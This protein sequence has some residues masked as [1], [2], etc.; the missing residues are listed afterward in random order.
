MRVTIIFF[1]A[2]FCQNSVAQ[3]IKTDKPDFEATILKQGV[4]FLGEQKTSLKKFR[5]VFK[6]HSKSTDEMYIRLYLEDGVE[7]NYIE[8]FRKTFQKL[9]GDITLEFADLDPN[10]KSISVTGS[11]KDEFGIGLENISII[12]KG[13]KR[14]TVTSKNGDFSLVI[15]TSMESLVIHHKDYS[16]IEV[17]Y[18]DLV[19]MNLRDLSFTLIK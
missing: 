1:I 9:N 4:Y 18:N 7:Y 8:K 11:V 5:K 6:E 14:G 12:A 3:K 10:S 17:P 13:T 2:L 19:S 16:K 15:P